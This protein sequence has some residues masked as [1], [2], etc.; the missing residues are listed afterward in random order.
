MSEGWG[1]CR[2]QAA[3]CSGLGE[4]LHHGAGPWGW[5]PQAAA[6]LGG[7]TPGQ[8]TLMLGLRPGGQGD[9]CTLLPLTD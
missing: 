9:R 1:P 6:R 2:S 4:G 7:Q 8:A 5:E 3:L